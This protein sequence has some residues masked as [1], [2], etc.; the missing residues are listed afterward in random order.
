MKRPE[1]S[2]PLV[3]YTGIAAVVIQWLALMSFVIL[4]FSFA[5]QLNPISYFAT[6]PATQQIFTYSFAISGL[7]VWAFVTF[8]ARRFI[9]ISVILFSLSM[10]CFIAM[11]TIPFRPDDITNL[12]QHENITATFALFF[13]LG[14]AHVGVRNKDRDIRTVSLI[15]AAIGL[16]FGTWAWKTPGYMHHMI[17][18]ELVCALTAQYWILWLS[19]SLLKLKVKQLP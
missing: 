7:L 5:E 1:L 12:V 11:A 4:D 3:A 6:R 9:R 19:R 13:V 14:M 17:L 18:L 16:I 2:A 8:W 15:C 10:A